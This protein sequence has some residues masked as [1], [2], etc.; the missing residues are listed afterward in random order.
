MLLICPITKWLQVLFFF[1]KWYVFRV[2]G[3]L[4]LSDWCF[5]WDDKVQ[6]MWIRA[7]WIAYF[8]SKTVWAENLKYKIYSTYIYV[9]HDPDVYMTIDY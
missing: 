7:V 4:M 9:S 8:L 1:V 3:L 2:Q 5:L 6:K